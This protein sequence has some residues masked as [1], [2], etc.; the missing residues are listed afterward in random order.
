MLHLNMIEAGVFVV[1]KTP[2][3]LKILK[4]VVKCAL[5]KD[6]MRPWLSRIYCNSAK[7]A[8]K[9]YANCHRYDQSALSLSLAQCSTNISDYF[10]PSDLLHIE[11]MPDNNINALLKLKK[12][13]S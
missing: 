9:E 3:S 8:R 5:V 1:S 10:G 6:C 13:L 4:T 11:R 7:L 2:Q 12:T